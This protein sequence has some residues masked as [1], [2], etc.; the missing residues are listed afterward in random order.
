VRGDVPTPCET[1]EEAGTGRLVGEVSW[2]AG[3]VA[4][5][6]SGWLA[7]DGAVH[8]VND[9]PELAELL[10]DT[11]GGNGTTTFGVPDLRG[12]AAI[13]EGDGPGLTQRVLGDDGGAESVT[14]SAEQLPAHS[15][16]ISHTHEAQNLEVQGVDGGHNHQ[17]ASQPLAGGP[18][19]DAGEPV[20][21][22]IGPFTLG[23]DNSSGSTGD[24]APHNNMQP[25]LVLTPMIYAGT[26]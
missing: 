6:P 2:F 22:Q 1:A 8:D 5:L 21:L 18:E 4:K 9:F 11:F 20:N 15:H 19:P 13:G 12:R 26:A 16:T 3:G 17:V 14:L 25:Y 24:G 7:C 10:G 23:G